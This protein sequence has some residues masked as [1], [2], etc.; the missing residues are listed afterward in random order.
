MPTAA[1]GRKNPV[2][3]HPI[4]IVYGMTIGEYAM[5]VNGEGWLKDG[6]KCDLTVVWMDQYNRRA[7]YEL[8]IKPSPNLPNWQS[9]YLYPSL[10]LF[11]G[12]T[13]SVGRGTDHPK[14]MTGAT[15]PLHKD[16]PCNGENLVSF[17]N[18]YAIVEER[19]HIEWLRDAY[20][21]LSDQP[22]FKPYFTTLMGNTTL[23]DSIIAEQSIEDIQFSWQAEIHDFMINK[24]NKYLHYL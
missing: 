10:C 4:P 23:K 6:M 18:D 8:P 17:A 2:G 5:M 21:Q 3:R 1:N 22:F 14:S 20:F 7:I 19:L 15:N 9:V 12:T 11:E 24:R 13:V 16:T